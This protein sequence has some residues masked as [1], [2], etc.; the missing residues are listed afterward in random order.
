MIDRRVSEIELLLSG[1]GGCSACSQHRET[2]NQ[3]SSAHRAFLEAG[4]KIGNDRLHV[5]SLSFMSPICS[6][7]VHATRA[8]DERA[9]HPVANPFPVTVTDVPS[10]RVRVAHVRG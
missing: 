3:F 7:L 1:A 4:Q 10:N 8:R 5:G 6:R 9:S 2:S